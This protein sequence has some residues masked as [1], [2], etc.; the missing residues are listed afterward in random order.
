MRNQGLQSSSQPV[1]DQLVE[2]SLEIKI[3]TETYAASM[4]SDRDWSELNGYIKSQYL[5]GV[6]NACLELDKDE[7]EDILSA[8]TLTLPKVAFGTRVGSEIIWADDGSGLLRLGYQFIKKKHPNIEY[9]RFERTAKGK[10]KTVFSASIIEIA[11]CYNHFY[12]QKKKQEEGVGGA[13][14]ENDKSE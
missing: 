6:R 8:A 11:Y 2:P 13:S 3:G 12:P 14:A 1:G 5:R 4:F 7:A 10:D 9:S